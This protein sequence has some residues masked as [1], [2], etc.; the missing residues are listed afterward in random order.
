MSTQIPTPELEWIDVGAADELAALPMRELKVGASTIA[1]SFRDG[2]FGA[3]SNRC[4]HVGGPLG[5][6]TLDGDFV[7]C[8]W[9]QY[10]F[11]RCSGAGEPGYEADRVPSFG[12]K[13]EHGRVLVTTTA[14]TPRGHL[15]KQPHPLARKP[16]R[17]AGP[18]RIAGI[19]TTIMPADHPR[20]STSE[21]LLELALAHAATTQ[22]AETRLIKLRDLKFRHCEGYY[23][24]DA[25]ACT[26]PCSITQMD[27]SDQL[28]VVYEA[29][30]HWA[31]VLLIATPIRWGAAS[32]LYF[33]MIERM[34]CIQNQITLANR[35]LI[36]RKTAAFIVTGGQDNVQ[37]V[38]GQQLAFF[39]ELGFVFPPFPF[40]GHSL[41]WSAE[42]MARNIAVVQHSEEL[43]AGTRALIER[44]IATARE[45]LHATPAVAGM[46]RGG[47]K[48]HAADDPAQG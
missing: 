16:E 34:N 11:D 29:A 47:R 35:V 13:V 17:A 36:Q 38:V 1:L 20:Y 10:K 43:R 3:V 9:H 45:Q 18:I 25:R 31:D 22:Q 7:V 40:V 44:A 8:P 41:G 12:V 33:K 24:R 4:N 6:G 26:W 14:V 2:R 48:A 32:S 21:A 28:A 37:A 27:D 19:S 30:V 42:N 46:A 39:A 5:Q 15:P 23:S